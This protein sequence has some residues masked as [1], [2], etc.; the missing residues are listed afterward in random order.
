[1]IPEK[2]TD[3]FKELLMVYHHPQLRYLLVESL[4]TPH[5]PMGILGLTLDNPRFQTSHFSSSTITLK[6]LGWDQRVR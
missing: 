3:F 6:K 4:A 5:I 2:F 1:V